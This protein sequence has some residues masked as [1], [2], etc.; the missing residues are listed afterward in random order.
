M[1]L[2]LSSLTFDKPLAKVW[3]ATLPFLAIFAGWVLIVTYLPW[4]STG[5]ET[6]LVRP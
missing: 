5:L 3:R 2:F 1:N 6:L 4:L